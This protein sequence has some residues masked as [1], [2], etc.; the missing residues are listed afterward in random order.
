[1]DKHI[2]KVEF[3]DNNIHRLIITWNDGTTVFV[4][5]DANDWEIT[6]ILNKIPVKTAFDVILPQFGFFAANYVTDSRECGIVKV[7]NRVVEISEKKTNDKH[8]VYINARQK[9]ASNIL[10]VTP[11]LNSFKYLGGNKFSADFAW[12][13]KGTLD[14]DLCIFVHCT[15]KK[16]SGQQL[17]EAVLGGGFPK[18]PVSQWKDK[19]VSD[20]YTMNIPNN[21]PAGQY[22][23]V[24]GLYD[25]K[26]DGRRATLLGFDTG[27]N[28]YAVGWLKVERK[29]SDNSVSNISLEPFKWADEK[30]SERFLPI[31]EPV[32][33]GIAETKGAFR[34]EINNKEKTATVTPLPDE[35]ATK[36]LLKLPE[37]AQSVKA[38]DADGKELRNVSF[39]NENKIIEFTTQEKEFAYQIKW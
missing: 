34:I 17:N 2:T 19:I 4:N 7:N 1:A 25:F 24:V 38:F 31:T 29:N 23:L 32:P 8:V 5:R 12:N 16:R 3:A 13:V 14:K 18:T 11:T 30:L 36:L 9:I 27:A 39:R 33:F 20:S 28:R 21:F 37:V 26:G 15:Q 6:N 22:Y 10:P 35:P